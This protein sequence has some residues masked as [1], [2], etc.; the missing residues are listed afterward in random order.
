MG[1]TYSFEIFKP[2]H[3][4][5]TV[6]HISNIHTPPI[7]IHE[8]LQ[9]SQ[10][11]NITRYIKSAIAVSITTDNTIDHDTKRNILMPQLSTIKSYPLI[12]FVVPLTDN[13]SAYSDLCSAL[14]LR[15][16]L[17]VCV[18]LLINKIGYNYDIQITR[19]IDDVIKNIKRDLFISASVNINITN[20]FVMGYNDSCLIVRNMIKKIDFNTQTLNVV[21]INP[22]DLINKQKSIYDIFI[23][24]TSIA[25]ILQLKPVSTIGDIDKKNIVIDSIVSSILKELE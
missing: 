10:N 5:Q 25:Q 15:N 24:N 3:L 9:V 11:T 13:I 23:Y 19:I 21:Y 6:N 18:K 4:R 12:I 2:I 17:V 14:A 20:L 8:S 16:Y 22:P 7:T 1:N